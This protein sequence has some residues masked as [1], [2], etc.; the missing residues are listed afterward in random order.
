MAAQTPEP[1]NSTS[2]VEKQRIINEL[3][4]EMLVIRT[5]RLNRWLTGIATFLAISGFIGFAVFP[6]LENDARRSVN[7]AQESVKKLKTIV[8]DVGKSA[9]QTKQIVVDARASISEA[10]KI[11]VTIQ[12]NA[13]ESSEL[14]DVV[15]REL[16]RAKEF[17]LEIAKIFT[18][19]SE[20]KKQTLEEKDKNDTP[21]ILNDLKLYNRKGFVKLWARQYEAAIKDYDVVIKKVNSLKTKSSEIYEKNWGHVKTAIAYR[22]RGRAKA[23]LRQYDKAITDYTEALKLKNDSIV[24]KNRGNAK[25]ALKKYQGAIDD[26]GKAI[27]LKTNFASA[28]YDRGKA[29]VALSLNRKGKEKLRL[30]KEAKKDFEEAIKLGGKSGNKLLVS[31]AERAL[32]GLTPRRPPRYFGWVPKP[33]ERERLLRSPFAPWERP[34]LR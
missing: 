14:L 17:R 15:R 24:Y 1:Q 26:Y 13:K 10:Q 18:E 7:N 9:K 21:K 8:D 4:R 23:A 27:N 11:I 30:R 25:A 22:N 19:V 12:E 16:G 29:K 5:E 31:S 6:K 2:E 34:Y 3:G 20:V 32:R 33:G 28:Y